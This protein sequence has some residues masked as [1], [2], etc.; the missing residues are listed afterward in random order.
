MD[1][2]TLDFSSVERAQKEVNRK[3]VQRLT[4]RILK[5]AGLTEGATPL[6][7][8]LNSMRNVRDIY[9]LAAYL[10]VFGEYDL[11]YDV[12]SILD[13]VSF[14]GDYFVWDFVAK[15]R[16]MKSAIDRMHNREDKAQQNIESIL[17]YEAPHLYENAWK[18]KQEIAH[19]LAMEYQ[20]AKEGKRTAS[21]VR[22]S[23]LGICLSC[24]HYIQL[25]ALPQYHST[26][27]EWHE[28]LVEFLRA[29]EK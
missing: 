29:E 1:T 26:M 17:P 20:E 11:C 3:V 25:G 7:F 8:S 15:C 14:K 22:Y 4:K 12:C 23:A 16:T 24:I 10:F 28:R 18:S 13:I 19:R 21:V 27:K 5:K 2:T 9:E 6:K